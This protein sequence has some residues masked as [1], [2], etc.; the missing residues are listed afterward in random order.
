MFHTGTSHKFIN[1]NLFKLL[2][3]KRC[4][5][6]REASAFARIASIRGDVLSE[7]LLLVQFSPLE[8]DFLCALLL[9]SFK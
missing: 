1:K 3:D 9:F 7:G 6:C 2:Q 4:R 8:T 5:W